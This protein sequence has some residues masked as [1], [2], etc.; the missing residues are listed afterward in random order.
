MEEKGIHRVWLDLPKYIELLEIKIQMMED[1]I[2]KCHDILG[3]S[4]GSD[5]SELYKYFENQKTLIERCNWQEQR[6]KE[7]ESQ[8]YENVYDN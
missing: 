3:E 8:I 4:R 5:I 2:N 1:A 6:I 7:L